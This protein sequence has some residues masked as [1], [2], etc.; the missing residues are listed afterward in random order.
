MSL[1]RLPTGGVIQSSNISI[2][3]GQSP[4]SQLSM[5]NALIRTLCGV[6]SGSIKWSDFY[7]KSLVPRPAADHDIRNTASYKDSDLLNVTDISGNGYNLTFNFAPTLNTSPK[8]IT[9]TT[10]NIRARSSSININLASG[11]SIELLLNF[12]S[13]P[14]N[15]FKIWSYTV[16]NDNQGINV[17]MNPSNQVYLYN[18]YT[19][20]S[21]ATANAL[22]SNTWYHVVFTAAGTIYVNGTSV[23]TGGGAASN[24][25]SASRYLT[26]GDQG[27]TRSMPGKLALAR[28]YNFIVSSNNVKIMY[29]AAKYLGSYG[30]P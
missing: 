23:A 7:A 4:T 13:N 16:A 30:L 14:A 22:S 29:N 1:P 10:S 11:Y 17:Q 8:S 25:T 2:A 12:T 3:I 27:A 15:Y 24:I 9:F 19:T 21:H 6:P 5:S 20:T 28:L 18:T 26:L